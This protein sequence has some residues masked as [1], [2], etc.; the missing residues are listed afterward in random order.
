MTSDAELL[1]CYLRENAQP[2][3]AELVQRHVNFVYGWALRRVGGNHTLAEETTQQVF[4]VLAREAAQ[5]AGRGTLQ[6][7]LYI[8]TRRVAA[9]ALRT[10]MRRRAREHA[11]TIIS[12]NAPGA[13]HATE[14]AELVQDLAQLLDRLD[15][16]GRDAL[17]QRYFAN[18]SYSEIGHALNLGEDGA[19]SRVNRALNQL[20]AM[21]ERRG[22]RSATAALT[23]AFAEQSLVAAP[24]TLAGRVTTR[25]LVAATTASS[26][27]AIASFFMNS[28]T[29]AVA[30]S[31]VALIGLG[32]LVYLSRDVARANADIGAA[33]TTNTALRAE[34]GAQH[35]RTSHAPIAFHSPPQSAGALSGSVPTPDG[36][37]ATDIAH[38]AL[39][40]K[41]NYGPL[42]QKLGLSPAQ[43]DVVSQ[44]LAKTYLQ[45]Q[46]I[47]GSASKEGLTLTDSAVSAQRQQARAELRTELQS[48]M[49]PAAYQQ[50]YE[51]SRTVALSSEVVSWVAKN[52]SDTANPLTA[53][54]AARL[55]QILANHSANYRAGGEAGGDV[56]WSGVLADA[57][58]VLAP[59]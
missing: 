26:S 37:T 36:F 51:Y 43:I 29:I 5:L 9:T 59:E 3:F 16:P 14:A 10:E 18:R 39:L 44:R 38:R 2:A 20:R 4:V 55:T 40:E 45:L 58:P 53:D 24:A 19:R 21:L 33:T 23:A 35:R 8:T 30:A 25:A 27:S 1:T 49:E 56:D 17:L 28:K 13:A 31:I 42:F 52:V 15:P 46:A 11:A 57:A 32:A 7:W 41:R 54:Q 34:A 22:I 50:L 6:G 12:E 48:T 47:N